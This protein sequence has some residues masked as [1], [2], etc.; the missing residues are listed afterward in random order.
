MRASQRGLLEGAKTR[1]QATPRIPTDLH[2]YFPLRGEAF[3]N[4][5]EASLVREGNSM[6]VSD[7]GL[8]PR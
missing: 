3:S 8:K 2:L 5:E 7:L 4:I 6:A 1:A